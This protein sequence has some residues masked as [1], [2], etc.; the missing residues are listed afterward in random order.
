MYIECLKKKKKKY[1]ELSLKSHFVLSCKHRM[2]KS[3]PVFL[4]SEASFNILF[5]RIPV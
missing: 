4:C 2:E 3:E 5:K 1:F